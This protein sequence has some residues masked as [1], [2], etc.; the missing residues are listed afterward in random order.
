MPY[1]VQS[2]CDRCGYSGSFMIGNWKEHLGVYICRDPCKSIVNVPLDTACCPGCGRTVSPDECYDYSHSI[3]YGNGQF[4]VEPEPGPS[5]PQC[6]SGTLNFLPTIHHNVWMTIVARRAD[7]HRWVGKDYLEKEIFGAALLLDCFNRHKDSNEA[8]AY[9]GLDATPRMMERAARLAK[10]KRGLSTPIFLDIKIHLDN[11]SDLNAKRNPQPGPAKSPIQETPLAP[12]SSSPRW[13]HRLLPSFVRPAH[14]SKSAT[15][16]QRGAECMA[17]GDLEAAIDHFSRA[18]RLDPRHGE[19]FRLRGAAW[20]MK[21][22]FDKAIE[23]YTEAIRLDPNDGEGLLLRAG[24]WLIKEHLDKAV[25]DSS[26]A[27]R[28]DATNADAF[29]ARGTAW[30]RMGQHDQAIVD[31]TEAI[32]LKPVNAAAF[33][34]RG[35]S[36]QQKG[37]LEKAIADFDT[38]IRLDP[39]HAPAFRFRGDVWA[40]KGNHE[41]VVADLTEVIRL[42]PDSVDAFTFR[43]AALSMLGQH[44]RA[45]A[46]LN[47][48]IRL[49]PQYAEVFQR[50]GMEWG[51]TGD[52]NRAISDFD[53][54]IRLNPTDATSFGLRGHAWT[55]MEQFD[56]AIEDCT[57]AI[58]L[59]PTY[60]EPFETRGRAWMKPSLTTVKPS[61]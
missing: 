26:V 6:G 32:R 38:T 55:Q 60:A 25:A 23:D 58:R 36:W 51:M 61:S 37:E 54:A 10:T 50:R 53:E 40:Q 7:A 59:E 35:L 4:F 31:L 47:E 17:K 56:K 8:F 49:D 19:A 28:L 1:T 18:A 39:N 29:R 42:T 12:D 46:D 9:F 21:E 45:I 13:W 14:D 41:K 44:E 48:A 30:G 3:P 11:W 52:L 57:E 2:R 22:Q 34:C 43:G 5:C 33:F 27:I 20:R 24:T 16:V 15:L